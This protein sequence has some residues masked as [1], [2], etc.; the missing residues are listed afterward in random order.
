MKIAEIMHQTLVTVPPDASLRAA[1]DLFELHG[2]HHLL[3]I[4]DG[5]LR[6]VLSDRDL[7]RNLSPFIGRALS[8]RHQDLA[9]LERRVHQIMSRKL[10]TVSPD[11]ELQEAVQIMLNAKVHCLPVVNDLGHA[12]GIVSS[13][14]LLAALAGIGD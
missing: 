9:T 12:V 10:V 11:T 7:L 13:V 2:Y 6:G 4:E 3:V 8:E 14:D 1:R 5:R